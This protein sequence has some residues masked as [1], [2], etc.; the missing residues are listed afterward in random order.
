MLKFMITPKYQNNQN[1]QETLMK[2]FF[3]N[4]KEER[5]DK[6]ID[7]HLKIMGKY[8]IRHRKL[9]IIIVQTRGYLSN[10]PYDTNHNFPLTKH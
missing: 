9:N 5:G 10:I 1:I 3:L 7:K 2:T 4:N 8:N 6:I